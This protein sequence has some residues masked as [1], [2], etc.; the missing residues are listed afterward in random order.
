MASSF[1]AIFRSPFENT[2]IDPAVTNLNVYI[3]ITKTST[4]D[5]FSV[6]LSFV[7]YLWRNNDELLWRIWKNNS[8]QCTWGASVESYRGLKPQEKDKHVRKLSTLC[9]TENDDATSPT[10]TTNGAV[11]DISHLVPTSQQESNESVQ[12][13]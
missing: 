12:E 7:F 8:I 2:I 3:R 4:G 11:A 10:K 1:A 5:E 13:L 9:G 6:I